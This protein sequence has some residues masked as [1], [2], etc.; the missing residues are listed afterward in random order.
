MIKKTA[1]ILSIF[2]F[3]TASAM[4]EEKVPM[5]KVQRGRWDRKELLFENAQTIF[6][7]MDIAHLEVLLSTDKEKKYLIATYGVHFIHAYLKCAVDTNYLPE[8]IKVV[9]EEVFRRNELFALYE[10]TRILSDKMEE[11][12][13]FHILTLIENALLTQKCNELSEKNKD[14]ENNE[15][16]F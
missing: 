15:A 8:K 14:N 7:S 5:E 2:S 12:N 11:I 13:L 16:T 3:F 9:K 4:E 10:N 1:C 6:K